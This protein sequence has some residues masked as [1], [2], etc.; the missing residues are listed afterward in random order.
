VSSQFRVDGDAY[1]DF[2]G[3]YSTV[4][5]TLFA[6]FA[7]VRSGMRALDVGA[8]TGALTAELLRRGASVAAADPSPEFVDV[9]RK[10]R[11]MN[12]RFMHLATRRFHEMV[13][14]RWQARPKTVPEPRGDAPRGEVP[15]NEASRMDGVAVRLDASAPA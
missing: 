2:M 10:M 3:R 7:D 14:A 12:Y 9:L 4:L 13:V 8:G 15:C 5:A 1:D 11:D 6:D